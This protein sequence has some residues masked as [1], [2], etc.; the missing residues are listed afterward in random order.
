MNPQLM[1]T[2]LYL[3][4]FF[5]II[6]FLLIR[7][8]QQQ[9]KK[10]QEMLNNVKVNDEI[11]TIGGIHGRVTR[12]TENEII[13]R[14]DEKTDLKIDRSAVGRIKTREEEEEEESAEESE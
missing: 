1:S 6:Y 7:P 3:L 5:V 14:V 9:Q 10:R 4:L 12:M 11:V 8:Q 2:I 13:I